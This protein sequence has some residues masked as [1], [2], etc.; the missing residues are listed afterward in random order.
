VWRHFSLLFVHWDCQS[1]HRCYDCCPTTSNPLESTHGAIEE[2]V[3]DGYLQSW[4]V[5]SELCSS[6]HIYSWLTMLQRICILSVVRVVAISKLDLTD[7]T[8]TIVLDNIM[9]A[10]EPT[11]GVINA[12]LPLLQPIIPKISEN[13]IITWFKSLTT[14]RSSATGFSKTDSKQ[15][16]GKF[17]SHHFDRLT[18]DLYPLTDISATRR[19]LDST[20][21]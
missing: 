12:C 9:S 16:S 18:P 19:S 10:L 17:A 3:T 5:V 15:P 4:G 11:L 8:Y 14:M 20:L 7:V 21:V 1:D 2:V 6:V 13:K